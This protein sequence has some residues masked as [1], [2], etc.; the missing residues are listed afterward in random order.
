MKKPALIFIFLALTSLVG[1]NIVS[2]LE[3]KEKTDDNINENTNKNIN[4][5][6]DKNT[7]KDTASPFLIGTSSIFSQ[8]VDGNYFEVAQNLRSAI[9]GKGLHIAHE[10]HAS[11]M[12]QRTGAAYGYK[13]STY[14][15][16]SI[17]EFCSAKL[18]QKLSRIHPDNI[19]LC[20]F[21]IGIY[22]LQNEKNMVHITYKIS[23]GKPGTEKV[24][25]EINE[26]ISS[27]IEDALW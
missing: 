4:E 1:I 17:L 26:L 10:L 22:S 8:K 25:E 14:S 15:N 5:S 12:L 27:I 6:I 19:V 23:S 11:D 7:N 18:S 24:V 3:A 9:L 13:K 20:P 16:A 2:N 21:T